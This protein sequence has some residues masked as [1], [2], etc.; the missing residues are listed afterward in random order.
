MRRHDA[1]PPVTGLLRGAGRTHAR[2]VL[3]FG[4]A[5]ASTAAERTACTTPFTSGARQPER[6]ENDAL[7][8]T[9]RGKAKTRNRR[10][11]L[12]LEIPVM[13]PPHAI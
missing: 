13:A 4:E 9:R 8:D 2:Q 7:R 3:R 10:A 11:S 5:F 1:G 6:S 12:L